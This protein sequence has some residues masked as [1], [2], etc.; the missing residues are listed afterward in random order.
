MR[1]VI[2]LLILLLAQS[3]VAVTKDP[4][5]AIREAL[6]QQV[7]AWN[8][9]DIPAY[10]AGYWHDPR[11]RFISRGEVRYGWQPTLEA[12]QKNYPDKATMGK[13]S[14]DVELIDLL[15]DDT[16]IVVGHWKL[17]RENDEPKGNFTLIYRRFEQG[18]RIIQDHSSSEALCQ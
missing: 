10:M 13:L 15:H 11:L 3:A 4:E 16:A 2:S 14:F 17:V 12:Y 8:K 6:Q 18:W 9:G 1:T 5:Q 7:V